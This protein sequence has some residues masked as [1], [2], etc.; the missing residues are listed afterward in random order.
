MRV[1]VSDF[2]IPRRITITGYDAEYIVNN[3]QYNAKI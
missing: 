2:N 3:F 1:N